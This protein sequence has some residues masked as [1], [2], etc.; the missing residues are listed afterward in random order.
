MKDLKRILAFTLTLVLLASVFAFALPDQTIVSIVSPAAN[1]VL[2]S[3]KLLVSVKLTNPG[4]AKITVYEQCIKNVEILSTGSAVDKTYSTYASISYSSVDTTSFEAI[5]LTSNAALAT[6]VSRVYKPA[7]I[8]TISDKIGFYTKQIS[9]VKPG[10]YKVVAQSL[11]ENGRAV[12]TV[13]SLIAVKEKPAAEDTAVFEQKQSGALK[14]LQNLLQ[15][16]FK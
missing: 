3:D 9:D 5:D 16:I 13:S 10:L 8:F 15:A 2:T 6:Y 12:E 11:D 14:L 7:E 1:S 4:S